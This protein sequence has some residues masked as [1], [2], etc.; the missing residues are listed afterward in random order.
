MLNEVLVSVA[1][2]PQEVNERLQT[3]SETRRKINAACEE[4]R[5]VARRATLLY[6]LIAE[7]AGVNCMYQVG[8]P[9]ASNVLYSAAAGAMRR[10]SQWPMAALL[11]SAPPQT[12]LAQF[13]ELYEKSI[14]ESE[15]A[16]LPA[17]RIHN[18]Q[19]HMT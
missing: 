11:G 15:R 19:E 1:A 9:G 3:A 16:S 6:F 2:R 5:P 8:P 10:H 17:K 12:S 14:D 4:Y 13:V 18:I 7:F